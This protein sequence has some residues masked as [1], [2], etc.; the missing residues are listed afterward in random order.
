MCI[1]NFFISKFQIKGMYEE[2]I[3]NLIK[4][5]NFTLF[6]QSY[7]ISIIVIIVD[8]IQIV[9]SILLIIFQIVQ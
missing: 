1:Q 3:I 5:D 4:K 8:H 7:L 2:N 6:L 9:F